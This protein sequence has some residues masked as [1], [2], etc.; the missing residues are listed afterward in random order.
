MSLGEP[1][2]GANLD[3]RGGDCSRSIVFTGLH[4][5]CYQLVGLPETEPLI[6]DQGVRELCDR[7]EVP[8]SALR[9]FLAIEFGGFERRRY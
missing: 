9:H 3:Q 8:A 6:A 1:Q 7:E 4:C 2:T 5:L